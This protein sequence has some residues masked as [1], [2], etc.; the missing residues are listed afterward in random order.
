MLVVVPVV[1]LSRPEVGEGE[2]TAVRPGESSL[3]QEVRQP[4]PGPCGPRERVEAVLLLLGG[5]GGQHSPPP[6]TA[7]DGG[8][9]VGRARHQRHALTA[10]LCVPGLTPSTSTSTSSS[11][12]SSSATLGGVCCLTGDG[13]TQSTE[14]AALY[15]T[16]TVA[17]KCLEI[18]LKK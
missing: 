6:L 14:K 7:E 5:H 10:N 18:K 1:W 9:I 3:V 4:N 17:W 13:R 8:E 11:T 16:L 2:G 15:P 12:S